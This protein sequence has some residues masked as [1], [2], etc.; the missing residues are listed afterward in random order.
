M[1]TRSTRTRRQVDY[2]AIEENILSSGTNILANPGSRQFVDAIESKLAS[3]PDSEGRIDVVSSKNFNLQWLKDQELK[4]PV[5]IQGLAGLGAKIPCPGFMVRD[6][7]NILGREWPLDVMDVSAQDELPGQWTI[8]DW[9][10]YY[11]TPASLRTKILNVISLEFSGSP[12]SPFVRAPAVIRQIDWID[13]I[14]PGFRRS[15][16]EYPAIQ[17]YCLMS[18]AGSWTDF[19]IDFGGSSVWY[20]V[21]TGIKEFI[22]LPPTPDNIRDYEQ[23][24]TSPAQ[25]RTFFSDLV[26]ER[27][28]LVPC[29]DTPGMYKLPGHREAFVITLTA[30][31]TMLIPAGWI[32]AVYTPVDSLVFGGNFLHGLNI[33]K[34]LSIYEMEIYTKIPRIYRFPFF[35]QLHW[36]AAGYYLQLFQRPE[37]KQVYLYALEHKLIPRPSARVLNHWRAMCGVKTKETEHRKAEQ[38][39]NLST[40]SSASTVPPLISTPVISPPPPPL[41]GA[42]PLGTGSS[43]AAQLLRSRNPSQ[44][45]PAVPVPL[46]PPPPPPLFGDEFAHSVTVPSVMAVGMTTGTDV[47]PDTMRALESSPAGALNAPVEPLSTISRE[48]FDACMAKLNLSIGELRGM[49]YLFTILCLL[50]KGMGNDESR[51]GEEQASGTT[52]ASDEVGAD[53]SSDHITRTGERIS[54]EKKGARVKGSVRVQ[55][56][57]NQVAQDSTTSLA[58]TSASDKKKT[59]VKSVYALGESEYSL[60][61][62]SKAAREAFAMTAPSSSEELLHP[63]LFSSGADNLLYNILYYMDFEE[64]EYYTPKYKDKPSSVDSNTLEKRKLA[65]PEPLITAFNSFDASSNVGVQDSTPSY[66]IW[67]WRKTDFVPHLGVTRNAHGASHNRNELEEFFVDVSKPISTDAAVIKAIRQECP[68]EPVPVNPFA[69]NTSAMPMEDRTEESMAAATS[70]RLG[71]GFPVDDTFRDIPLTKYNELIF[72]SYLDLSLDSAKQLPDWEVRYAK[73]SLSSAYCVQLRL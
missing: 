27:S 50:R 28:K 26:A 23:W 35:E 14:W 5:L 10:D 66:P 61:P 1:S 70:A 4:R 30:G 46:P 59:T 37:F 6:V 63:T 72:P 32:H 25:S 44:K 40:Q 68:L 56:A 71:R 36:Y 69:L 64:S 49:P 34:Q 53:E 58:S 47:V 65:T 38:K 62:P 17:K 41:F 67:T 57:T 52:S 51:E 73:V 3:L 54:M 55:H 7:G 20:H 2:A 15:I 43:I 22:F 21:H 13:N 24:T 16:G 8:G 42:P 31:N 39:A 18:V 9:V 12:L 19:H 29:S 45:P 48:Q 60:F 33:Q 11:E